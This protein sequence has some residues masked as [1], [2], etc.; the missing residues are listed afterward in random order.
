[1]H[2]FWL[3]YDKKQK[4]GHSQNYL[5]GFNTLLKWFLT[6]FLKSMIHALCNDLRIYKQDKK[7]LKQD[8]HTETWEKKN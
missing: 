6:A 5:T 3:T 7:L 2:G 1:M 4:H 8:A